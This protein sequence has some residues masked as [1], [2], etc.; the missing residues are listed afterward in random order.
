VVLK[1]KFNAGKQII[2]LLLSTRR[3]PDFEINKEDVQKW[4]DLTRGRQGLNK[5]KIQYAPPVGK[6][7][8][9]YHFA[10]VAIEELQMMQIKCS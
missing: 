9:L 10:S 1:R 6:Y 8:T 3:I 5:G 2:H 7:W 4:N